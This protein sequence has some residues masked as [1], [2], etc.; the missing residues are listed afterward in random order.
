M[1]LSVQNIY[2]ISKDKFKLNLVAGKNGLSRNISWVYYTEDSSTIKYIRGGELAITLGVFI[3]RNKDNKGKLSESL[4]EYLKNLVEKFVEH[5]ASGLII[6]TGKYITEIP[7]EIINL[8]NRLDFPLF[9]MPWEIHTIDVMEEIGNRIA[10]DRQNNLTVETF[11]Y[12]AIFSPQ[13]L[14][15][16]QILNTPFNDAKEFSI[17]LLEI[18]MERFNND[19]ESIKRYVTYSF[20]HKLNI[21]LTDFVC[22]IHNQK[23]I[24]ILKKNFLKYAKEIARVAANDKF[25]YGMKTS[26]SDSTNEIKNL[27]DIYTHAIYANNLD[28]S[29]SRVCE[30][31]SLGLYKL[32]AEIKNKNIL[33][34]MYEETLGKLKIFAKDK[35]SD[36]MKTLELFL[37][38]GGNMQKISEENSTH[39]NTVI[40]RIRR[41]E[42]T[43]GVDLGDG[44]V[45]CK[46]QM[47]IYIGKVLK[48]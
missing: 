11:F 5:N 48:K 18:N 13:E 30:Y 9:T 25:F 22:F 23:A 12:K 34:Q 37:K 38:F 7:E 35:L 19:I 29:L 47:A 36:Y 40:Y 44:D 6:N 45:R 20:N 43:L 1:P 4:T 27:P 41:I 2:N 33:E 3:S 8:C 14:D 32:L 46:I 24:Y 39:R 10:T 21:Q 17:A 31:N 16:N 26:L 15:V 28:Q 42:E